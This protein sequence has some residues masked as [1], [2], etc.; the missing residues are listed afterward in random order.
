MMFQNGRDFGQDKKGLW[1]GFFKTRKS[2]E[3]R[4]VWDSASS[5]ML[6]R[7]IHPCLFL[8]A[9]ASPYSI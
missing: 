8:F 7:H 6:K 2:G 5:Q 4:I 9:S 3:H 1:Q